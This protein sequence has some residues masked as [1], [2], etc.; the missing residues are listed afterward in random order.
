MPFDSVQEPAP[1]LAEQLAAWLEKQN[2]MAIYDAD[3][4]VDCLLCQWLRDARNASF[5]SYAGSFRGEAQN[6]RVF[7]TRGAV[8]TPV[9]VG[10]LEYVARPYSCIDRY[11]DNN[12]TFGAALARCRDFIEDEKLTANTRALVVA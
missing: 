2:P 9:D 3:N 5:V 11:A 1:T 10:N 8:F 6:Y 4:G 12:Q 7:A